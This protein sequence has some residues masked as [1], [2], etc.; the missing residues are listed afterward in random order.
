MPK[1]GL[2]H[3]KARHLEVYVDGVKQKYCMFADTDEG[4]ATVY[5][6]DPSPTPEYPNRVEIRRDKD[7][8][9]LTETIWGKVEVKVKGVSRADK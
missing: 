1:Y 9:P 4:W 5:V 6:V 7:R 3:P 2:D 8:N